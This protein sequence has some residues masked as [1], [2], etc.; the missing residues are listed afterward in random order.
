MVIFP[1]NTF[2]RL[3][4]GL[5]SANLTIALA[6]ALAIL[7]TVNGDR[8]MAR[9]WLFSFFIAMGVVGMTKLAFVAWGMA[10]PPFDFTGASGHAARA[11]AVYPVLCFILSK[12]RSAAF[13]RLA[14]GAAL[15]LATG[16]A[17]SRLARQVHSFSEVAC[18]MGIGVMVAATYMRRAGACGRLQAVRA[19]PWLGGAVLCAAILPAVPTQAWLN[20]A[21]M[22]LSGRPAPYTRQD[23]RIKPRTP[24]PFCDAMQ[25][26][27][28][29]RLR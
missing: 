14:L 3:L 12:N 21:G 20:Q 7:L 2:W 15:V 29:E 8:R 25:P 1:Y 22:A 28:T 27:C 5:G 6:L 19:I 23:A 17:C 4:S 18:G 16:I 26:G 13:Q 11:A 10:V 24:M 9:W